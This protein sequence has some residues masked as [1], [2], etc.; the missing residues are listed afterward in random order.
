[1]FHEES[2]LRHHANRN[3]ID[4]LL[5]D[6]VIQPVAFASRESKALLEKRPGTSVKWNTMT[7]TPSWIEGKLS[8]STIG[9]AAVASQSF[10]LENPAA[11]GL[12]EED[13]EEL[14]EI[15][16]FEWSG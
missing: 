12:S 14:T 2:S 5:S 15:D 16:S 7:G 9:T 3:H 6:T 10:L 8:T 11:L 1:M 13:A 4:S